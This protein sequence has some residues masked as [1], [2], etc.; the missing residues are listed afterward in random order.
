MFWKIM[1]IVLFFV[2]NVFVGLHFRKRS[3]STDDFI[4]GSRNMGPWLSAFAYGTTY[5]SAT[6][7]VGY[8]GQ[9]G[10]TFGISSFWIGI[11]N[12]LIGSLMAWMLLGRRTRVMTQHLSASTMPEFFARRYDS[13]V[14]KIVASMIIFVFLVPYTASVYKGLSGLFAISFGIDF[15]WCIFGMAVLTGIF[16]IAGGYMGTAVNNVIQGVIMLVG[17]AVVV[18]M[19]LNGQ[20]GFTKAIESLSHIK[21]EINPSLS[22]ALTSMFGP[23]PLGLLSVCILTSLGAW[24]MPQMVH[25]FYAIKDEN[26]IKKGTLIST[27]FALVI[28]GGSYFMGGFGRLYYTA[29][30]VVYDNIVPTMVAKVMS[31]AGVGLILIVVLSAS[32]S[33]LAALVLT[34]ASTFITDFVKSFKS[35]KNITELMLIRSMCAVFILIS[36]VIAMNPNALITTLMSLSWGAMAGAFLGP[37][38]Y[39]LFWKGTTIVSVWCSMIFGVGFVIA[40][41]FIGFTSPTKAA[42]VSMIASLVIVP[43]ISFITPKPDK[44]FVEKAFECFNET[45][46]THLGD[47]PEKVN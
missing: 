11:G 38:I 1:F 2:V 23:D 17:I 21:S 43:L 46:N 12:A 6:I 37:F 4:L 39:G 36:V 13:N 5:F 30:K 27:L 25:K 15:K 40:N 33:T 34:S 41:Y 29:D 10:W 26:A 14:L 7:F 16:V 44:K 8:A 3:N 42:A 22:G 32:I 28:A 19:V 35:M 20:G 31:D 18:V 47:T 24:G 9:F 45:V